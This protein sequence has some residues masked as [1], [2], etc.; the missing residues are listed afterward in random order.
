M[1]ELISF[2]IQLSSELELAKFFNVLEQT[3]RKFNSKSFN[4]EFTIDIEKVIYREKLFTSFE[5]FETFYSSSDFRFDCLTIQLQE[6]TS[7]GFKKT[8]GNLNIFGRL[9]NRDII[10]DII[11]DLDDDILFAYLHNQTDLTLSRSNKYR[12]WE[13]KLGVVP[14]YVKYH[15]NPRFSGGERDKYL[16][17][18]E[19]VPTHQH[20]IL[21][22]DKLWFGS[23]AIMY[24]SE[25]YYKYI[26]KEKWEGFIDCEENIVLESG[27]RKVVLYNDLSN[28]ENSGNRNKQWTF[29]NQ[30]GIDEVAHMLISQS[31]SQA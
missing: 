3:S 8:N 25:L 10:E 6:N 18:L 15:E 9:Q 23:C 30:L 21:T 24:F 5:Q 16:I 14:D 2:N 26:P 17:D 27:L 1:A 11:A 29:R 22:G 19:S 20:F 28:Y 12:S 13:R 7:I 31:R 4:F